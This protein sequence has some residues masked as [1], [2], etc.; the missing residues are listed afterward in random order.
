MRSRLKKTN[1]LHS[2]GYHV[3]GDLPS[4]KLPLNDFVKKSLDRAGLRMSHVVYLSSMTFWTVVATLVTALISTPAAFYVLPLLDLPSNYFT[5][6]LVSPIIVGAVTA[7]C[8]LY[9]PMTVSDGIKSKL[10][11]NMVYIINYMSVLAGAGI[12]TEDVFNSFAESKDTY[13]IRNSARSIVRDISMLGKDVISAI[14]AEAKRTPSKKYFK[15]LNGL[16]GITKS[17]GDLKNYLEETAKHEQE[18]RR[19][20]LVDIVNKLNMAAEI[21]ITLGIA[22]PVILIVLLSLMGIFGGT[23]G[24]GLSPIQLIQ[25]MTYAIFPVAA[26]GIILLIDGMT[27]NW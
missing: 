6:V 10:D 2:I 17:G 16:L 20:E 23:V 14:E 11:K 1:S 18:V 13:G 9:Y 12:M 19:R 24:G 22:F 8:F 15:L 21:Y 4:R 27:N 26:I 25:L 7:V 5:W 3:L